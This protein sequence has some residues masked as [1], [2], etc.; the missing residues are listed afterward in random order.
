MLLFIAVIL[1]M[2]HVN[3]YCSV[4]SKFLCTIMRDRLF[5]SEANH[6]LKV[7]LRVAHRIHHLARRSFQTPVSSALSSQSFSASSSLCANSEGFASLQ[8]E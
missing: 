3:C 8:S 6:S 5:R 2:R 4:D 1:D 7:L